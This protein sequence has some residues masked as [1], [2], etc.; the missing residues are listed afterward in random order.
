MMVISMHIYL[1]KLENCW[2]VTCSTAAANANLNNG[3]ILI[4]EYSQQNIGNRS[5]YK[6]LL[7]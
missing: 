5:V 2:N 1:I 4:L 7:S 3:N 6:D